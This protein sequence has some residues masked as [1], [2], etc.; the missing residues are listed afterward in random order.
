LSPAQ[1]ADYLA[2]LRFLAEAEG[3]AAGAVRAYIQ[4]ED[5]MGSEFYDSILD[6]GLAEG[7]A[8]GLAEGR[9][10]GLAEGRAEG[11]A[12]GRAEGSAE[13]EMEVRRRIILRSL[14][15]RLGDIDP[16]LQA[17]LREVED[18]RALTQWCEAV[19]D[20]QDAEG[21]RR[22]AEAILRGPGA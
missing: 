16:G 11:R 14:A 7:R 5:V 8:Q 17:R 13:A 18:L 15:R 12:Q 1:R 10:Q 22:L 3:M 20:V 2:V 6:E 21:A 4:K 9:A 19:I